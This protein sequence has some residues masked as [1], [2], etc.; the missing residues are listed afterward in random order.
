[1]LGL[2]QKEAKRRGARTWWVLIAG[3]GPGEDLAKGLTMLHL[4][5]W[6][7]AAAVAQLRHS[8]GGERVSERAHAGERLNGRRKASG[9]LE[10]RAVWSPPAASERENERHKRVTTVHEGQISLPRK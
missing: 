1:V 8:E 3:E 10:F 6:R 9:E 2:A 4:G 5:T 7:R